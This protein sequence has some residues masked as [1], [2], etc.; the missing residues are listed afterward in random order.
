MSMLKDKF[1][2]INPFELMKEQ[3]ERVR[4]GK[5][6][7]KVKTL[8]E[9]KN[10]LKLDADSQLIKNTV[11]ANDIPENKDIINYIFTEDNYSYNNKTL[12]DIFKYAYK[13]NDL[14]LLETIKDRHEN[15]F[16]DIIKQNESTVFLKDINTQKDK[17]IYSFVTNNVKLQ[18]YDERKTNVIFSEIVNNKMEN[19]LECL[20]NSNENNK[21]YFNNQIVEKVKFLNPNGIDFFVEKCN[22]SDEQL[23]KMY[24]NS[25]FQIG[26]TGDDIN[27]FID[28]NPEE[29]GYEDDCYGSHLSSK[30][31]E[32]LNKNFTFST[33]TYQDIFDRSINNSNLEIA[34]QVLSENNF[35][36]KVSSLLKVKKDFPEFSNYCEK[37]KLKTTFENK[38]QPKQVKLNHD[39]GYKI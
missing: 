5:E 19:N 16:N 1:G 10:F 22:P 4:V 27:V 15:V 23:S 31:F 29:K 26:S 33:K 28:S 24:V 34:K 20:L 37:H 14:E 32:Y 7:L 39:N 12:T 18:D 2:N 6:Y 9:F 8:D 30:Q 11:L 36:P 3:Q 25:A 38:I 35:I 13:N 17:D 21:E